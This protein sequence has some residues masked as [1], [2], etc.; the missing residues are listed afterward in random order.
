MQF[1][2]IGTIKLLV[3]IWPWQVNPSKIRNTEKIKIDLK[4]CINAVKIR[5]S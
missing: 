4:S 1:S 5:V 3:L 2:L